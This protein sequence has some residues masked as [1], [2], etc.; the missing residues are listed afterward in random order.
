[1]RVLLACDE[2][3]NSG[4]IYNFVTTLK[5]RLE[6]LGHTVE[7]KETL[8][9]NDEFD[10]VWIHSISSPARAQKIINQSL[11]AVVAFHVHDYRFTC[12]TA[13]KA[14]G[15]QLKFCHKAM[16]ANCF[17]THFM[18]G[19]GRGKNPFKLFLSY[20]D[21]KQWQSLMRAHQI[22]VLSHYLKEELCNNNFESNQ[23]EVI[24]A[25][26]RCFPK[27]ENHELKDQNLLWAG[28]LVKEKGTQLIH[29]LLDIHYHWPSKLNL[30][31]VGS[32][33]EKIGLNKK[34]KEYKLENKVSILSAIQPNDMSEH[35]HWATSLL[36]TS[37]WPEP[38]GMVGPEAIS[39]GLHVFYFKT[40]KCGA[41]EWIEK[42]SR[43]CHPFHSVKTLLTVLEDHSLEKSSVIPT[44]QEQ[45]SLLKDYLERQF[46]NSSARA[47]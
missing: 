27:I 7:I 22:T 25:I 42:Y 21:K 35:Y 36:Y 20:Q 45:L 28:R 31:I 23:I 46:S 12:L 9:P 2:V 15:S 41:T 11:K 5:I 47:L 3:E 13:R 14:V 26:F 30:R 44:E 19:C 39:A 24:P 33:P 43:L 32:G 8:S 16:D 6:A 38:F 37:L 10:F 18:N 4:G 29:E 1:M 40:S 34:I 17:G